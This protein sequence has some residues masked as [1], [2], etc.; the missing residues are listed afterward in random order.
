M[1]EFLLRTSLPARLSGGL[2][3][4][5]L[6]RTGSAALLAALVRRNQFLIPLD[7]HHEWY[8]YHHLF[9]GLPAR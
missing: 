7:E 4:A 9:A 2:C 8:R 5:M 6:E 3:D 1:R